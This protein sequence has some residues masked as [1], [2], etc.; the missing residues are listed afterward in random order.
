MTAGIRYPAEKRSVLPL[1]GDS[2]KCPDVLLDEAMA[3][4][5]A[6]NELALPRGYGKNY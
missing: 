6:E 3:F 2:E 5:D 4:A 1:Q